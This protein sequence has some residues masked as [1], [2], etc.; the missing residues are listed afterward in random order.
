MSHFKDVLIAIDTDTILRHFNH[1][2]S[3]DHNYPTR[4]APRFAEDVIHMVSNSKDTSNQGSANITSTLELGDVIRWRATT[5]SK[6][7]ENS[8][9]LYNYSQ[10]Y[11]D[12][13][14]ISPVRIISIQGA[15]MPVINKQSPWAT[16]IKQEVNTYLWAAT[17]E[18]RGHI[19]YTWSFMIV[20]KHNQ[21][22][23]Y[24]SWDPYM[25]IV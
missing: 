19:T 24:C 3:Q 18:N 10:L 25:T 5:L 2:I 16:P 12:G 9:I 14:E 13:G 6:D 20:D 4:I 7:F 15:P 22:V 23:G 8:V 1:D 11:S 21:V 17:A